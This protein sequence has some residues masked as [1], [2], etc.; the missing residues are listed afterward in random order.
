MISVTE[1][2]DALV[3]ETRDL[4]KAVEGRMADRENDPRSMCFWNIHN[5]TVMAREIVGLYEGA[6]KGE[7]GTEDELV[8]RIMSSTRNLFVNSMSSIEKG[9]RDCMRI[10]GSSPVR[11]RA[12]EKG[13]RMY[14][15]DI[16]EASGEVGLLDGDDMDRWRKILM[17][18]NLVVHNNAVS[19]RS[20]VLVLG[21]L[22]ISM[23]P[24]RMMKGPPATYVVL[25]SMA[26]SMFYRWMAAIDGRPRWSRRSCGTRC[27][28]GTRG[29]G[30]A[31]LRYLY[32]AEGGRLT[33]DA[34]TAR[35][36]PLWSRRGWR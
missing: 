7:E 15:R 6:W 1:R 17:L 9:A 36:S 8:D 29:P 19:D 18:R 28:A 22:R 10:Y 32:P 33:S 14:L 25:S 26:A 31:P 20:E 30:E 24:E 21:E 11:A 12:S 27:T 23:R 13:G 34:G 4:A 2:I 16:L 3:S 5:Q 35:R